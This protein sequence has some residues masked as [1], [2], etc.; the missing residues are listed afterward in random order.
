MDQM[1]FNITKI[2]LV[3]LALPLTSMAD[4]KPAQLFM[5]N[6]V[7]QRE[8]QAAVWG[9]ADAGEKVT[10]TGS[11]GASATTTA[12]ESGKWMVKLKTPKAGGPY[13]ITFKGKNTIELKNVLSG[14]VWLCSGQ[15][16]M[17][18]FVSQSENPAQDIANANYPQIRSFMVDRKLSLKEEDDCGGSWTVCSPETVKKFSAVAYFTGREL[19]K[20]LD[21][22]IGLLTSCYGGTCI[23]G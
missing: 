2:V 6:M 3:A 15:S 14:D 17:V 5:D 19:H 13:T 4:V 18:R 16:N 8:T 1:K 10:V 20:N 22:P 12:D 7:I 23:E 21:V 9:M 11:W